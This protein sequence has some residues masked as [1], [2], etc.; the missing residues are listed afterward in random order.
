[1]LSQS[2][3][4]E[5]LREILALQREWEAGEAKRAY[6]RALVE[7]R[8]DLPAFIRRDQTV[9]FPSAKGRVHYTHASLAAAMETVVPILTRHGFSLA[10]TPGIAEKGGVFVT[11]TLTHRDGHSEC[12]TLS[13]PA[14]TSGSKSPAQGV[15]STVTL[16]QRYTA[17]SLLGIATADMDEPKPNGAP[18][19]AGAVDSARNMRAMAAL[20]KAGKTREEAEKIAGRPVTEWTGADLAKLRE[21]IEPNTETASLPQPPSAAPTEADTS[22]LWKGRLDKIEVKTGETKGKKWTLYS[23]VASSGERFGTFSESDADIARSCVSGG[24]VAVIDSE[25]TKNGRRIKSI[26]PMDAESSVAEEELPF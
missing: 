15:A 24:L 20:A 16:L 8:R 25:E 23:V 19:D 12:A 9:D 10:W 5:T 13:A 21:W 7:L 4:P 17:L 18:P 2:P 1:M 11:A 22:G 3:T 14:D 6:T 26:V